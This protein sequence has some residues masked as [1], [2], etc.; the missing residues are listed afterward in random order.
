MNQAKNT[1][2]EIQRKRAKMI[3]TVNEADNLILDVSG[4][5]PTAQ[6]YGAKSD[7]PTVSARTESGGSID[8]VISWEL[9]ERLA[10]KEVMEVI[11]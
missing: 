6:V 4:Q 8:C 10:D 7:F 3:E 11:Y 9:L 2:E 1:K 5:K